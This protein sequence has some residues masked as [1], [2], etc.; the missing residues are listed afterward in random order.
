M[1]I[2]FWQLIVILVIILL[3]FGAGKV[4]QIAGDIAKGLK[5]FKKNIKDD[6]SDNKNDKNGEEK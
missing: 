1:S 3:L 5:I 2:G 6:D 4:P